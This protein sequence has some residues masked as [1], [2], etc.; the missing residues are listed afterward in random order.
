MIR[1]SRRRACEVSPMLVLLVDIHVKPEC[2]E[3]FVAAC[4][5]NHR[6]SRREPGNLRW[7]FL[8]NE[9]EPERYTLYEVY[10]DPA[11][12]QAHQQQPHY[13]AWRKAVEPMMATP[14]TRQKLRPLLPDDDTG[15]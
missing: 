7:D 8:Q 11:A 9:E 13:L 4:T 15:F 10:R 5:A 6:G 1:A 2:R 14:R 12:L 3:A